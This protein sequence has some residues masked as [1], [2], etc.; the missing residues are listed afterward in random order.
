MR[1]NPANVGLNAYRGY[2]DSV[3]H[4]R[5]NPTGGGLGVANPFNGVNLN[6]FDYLNRGLAGLGDV[7]RKN[8]ADALIDAVGNRINEVTRR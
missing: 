7:L 6:P 3:A 1:A 8:P 2:A 4:L 5:A